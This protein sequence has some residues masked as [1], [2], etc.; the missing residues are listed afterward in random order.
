LKHFLEQ[1]II[2]DEVRK[3]QKLFF[4]NTIKFPNGLK[5]LIGRLQMIDVG[6]MFVL[7]PSV[8][9]GKQLVFG[10]ILMNFTYSFLKV[11]GCK[12]E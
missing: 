11:I 4:V 1:T 7:E 2:A 3:H 9:A 10:N 5:N 8:K 12:F 6:G